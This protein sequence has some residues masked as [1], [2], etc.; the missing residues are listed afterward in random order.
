MESFKIESVT[1]TMPGD[2][3]E[4]ISELA[5]EL[6]SGSGIPEAGEKASIMLSNRCHRFHR[7]FMAAVPFDEDAD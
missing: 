5:S 2:L 7:E 6:E 1:V 3:W 4:A